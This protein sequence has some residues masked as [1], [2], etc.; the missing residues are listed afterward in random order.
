[1]S[2]RIGSA[3]GQQCA[4]LHAFVSPQP[5][6][7]VVSLDKSYCL[8]DP[9]APSLLNVAHIGRG[10]TGLIVNV[11]GGDGRDLRLVEYRDGI[12]LFHLRIIQIIAAGE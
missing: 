11:W 1:M 9:E 4:R 8:N 12:G 10:R 5:T 2:A 6:L 3:Q 7:H